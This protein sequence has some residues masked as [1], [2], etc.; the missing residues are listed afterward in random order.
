MHAEWLSADGYQVE[1]LDPVPRHVERAARLAGVTARLGDARRLPVADASLDVVLLLGLLYHLPERADRV[2]ARTE[3]RRVLRPG[4]VVAAAT[5]N[6]PTST[7]PTTYRGNSPTRAFPRSNGT[8][9]RAPSGCTAMSATGWTTRSAEPSCSVRGQ[10]PPAQH[11]QARRSPAGR[12]IIQST[13]FI[14]FPR[15]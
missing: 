6:P 9:W 11:R 14:T 2:R 1:L 13:I 4:G 7:T 8:T 5:I 10:R 15:R 3:A 12:A